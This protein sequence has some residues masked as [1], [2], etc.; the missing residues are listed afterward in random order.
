MTTNYITNSTVTINNY[1]LTYHA[2][3]PT[4]TLLDNN[5]NFRT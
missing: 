5:Q 1:S 4:E 2:L 3:E